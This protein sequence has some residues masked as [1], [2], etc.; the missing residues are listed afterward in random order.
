MMRRMSARPISIDEARA[1]VL[2]AVVPLACEEVPVAEAGGR[3]LGAELRA[4]HDVPPF[5]NS[6]MDGYAVPAGAATKLEVTG[7][8]R[9]G[10]PAID[11]LGPGAAIPISTGA[12]LPAG[13]DAVA[14][15][16]NTVRDGDLVTLT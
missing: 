11:V 3:V 13:A 5:D 1:R 9:A 8:S 16:E 15:V 7:E 10:S 12:V 6:A 4:A 14:P 2:E